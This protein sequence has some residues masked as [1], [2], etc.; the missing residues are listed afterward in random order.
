MTLEQVLPL[1][2]PL[3]VIDLALIVFALR[4]LL[5]P[6]RRVRGGDKRLWAVVIILVEFFG[7]LLYL[8]LGRVDE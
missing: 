5:R 6:E 4:D 7:P 8:T 1:I 2:L 3:L